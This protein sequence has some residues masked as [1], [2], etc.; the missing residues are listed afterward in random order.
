[1]K[2]TN[3]NVFKIVQKLRG[4]YQKQKT[5][6]TW[7]SHSNCMSLLNLPDMMEEF[8]PLRNLWEGGN[9]GEGFLRL[10]K[11]TLNK[12]TRNW[13]TNLHKDLLQFTAIRQTMI[14]AGLSEVINGSQHMKKFMT[15]T[16]K[17][18]I[19]SSLIFNHPLSLVYIKGSFYTI[20]EHFK[21][22][23]AVC[24]NVKPKTMKCISGIE[25]NHLSLNT[26]DTNDDEIFDKDN[27]DHYCLALPRFNINGNGNTE[28]SYYIISSEWSEFRGNE[29]VLYNS[30]GVQY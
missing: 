3:E 30:F 6:P 21:Q 15:Y 13:K 14:D 4:K 16:T 20:Y 18:D 11:P 5:N 24:M 19:I 29:F 8:G 25:W 27:V 1:M 7:L 26:M 17:S 10:T 23:M 22:K 2:L 28:N 9:C 12:I